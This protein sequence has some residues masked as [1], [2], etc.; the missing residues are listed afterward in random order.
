MYGTNWCGLFRDLFNLK[1][2]LRVFYLTL[3]IALSDSNID[4]FLPVFPEETV[5]VVSEK[6][7]FRF[8]KL[9]CK[10]KMLNVK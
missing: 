9:K 7:I 3:Q 6:V 10:V 2:I 4:F 5:T 1:T 8:N